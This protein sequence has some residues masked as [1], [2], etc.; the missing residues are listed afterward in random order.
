MHGFPVIAPDRQFL[1]ADGYR[2]GREGDDFRNG[3]NK[4]LVDPDE[5]IA[6]QVLFYLV[7]GHFTIVLYI[8]SDTESARSGT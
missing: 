4:G 1:V 6:G 2:P 5:L 8:D 3:N 7:H